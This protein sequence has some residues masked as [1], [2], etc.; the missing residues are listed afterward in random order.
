MCVQWYWCGLF[1]RK[2]IGTLLRILRNLWFSYKFY[3][4]RLCLIGLGVGASRIVLLSLSFFLLLVLHLKF[5]HCYLLLFV[6]CCFF[7]CS[8]SWTPCICFLHLFILINIILITYQFF[9]LDGL[10]FSAQ[11][12][13]VHPH[14][15]ELK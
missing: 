7:L 4:G 12:W 13:V 6:V 3:A 9:F 5:F 2:E 10:S 8:P 11:H 1:G 15:V 14:L